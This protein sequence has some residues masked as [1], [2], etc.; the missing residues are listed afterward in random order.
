M[1]VIYHNGK[2]FQSVNADVTTTT[3]T[4]TINGRVVTADIRATQSP[5]VTVITRFKPVRTDQILKK[6]S[7]TSPL[8]PPQGPIS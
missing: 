7:T 8:T 6:G 2:L 5:Q 3:A 4:S 1:F